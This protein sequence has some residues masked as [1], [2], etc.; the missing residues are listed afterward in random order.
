MLSQICLFNKQREAKNEESVLQIAFG[1]AEDYLI[2]LYEH[3]EI[4]E[5]TVLTGILEEERN[6]TSYDSETIA[7]T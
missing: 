2:E 4:I 5:F 6:K 1:F 3:P 7:Y